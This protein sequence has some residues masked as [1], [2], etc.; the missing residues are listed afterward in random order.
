MCA[1]VVY[2]G[3]FLEQERT[4]LSGGDTNI[5]QALK[6]GCRDN[7]QQSLNT[8]NE[9]SF[10]FQRDAAISKLAGDGGGGN[11]GCDSGGDQG[12]SGCSGD[13]GAVTDYMR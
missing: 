4:A 7:P 9:N 2:K 12:G 10:T 3:I 5:C 6:Q 13:G 11:I 8:S 1:R